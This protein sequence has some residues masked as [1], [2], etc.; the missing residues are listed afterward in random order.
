[1]ALSAIYLRCLAIF[2]IQ[3]RARST[4]Y[5]DFQDGVAYK[6]DVGLYDASGAKIWESATNPKSSW[7]T[8][9]DQFGWMGHAYP[10]CPDS[11]A[12]CDGISNYVGHSKVWNAVG[13][14][15][16]FNYLETQQYAVPASFANK[17]RSVKFTVKTPDSDAYRVMWND[18]WVNDHGK[19]W[20]SQ[21]WNGGQP[22]PTIEYPSLGL[23]PG[24]PLHI[25]VVD[26]KQ[27][28][29]QGNRVLAIWIS[30]RSDYSCEHGNHCC[31]LT[32]TSGDG[33]S[34]GFTDGHNCKID[35]P[36]Y[37][38]FTSNGSPWSPGS[39]QNAEYINFFGSLTSMADGKPVSIHFDDDV[40]S[41]IPIT[42][43]YAQ[44]E[45][46][47][48]DACNQVCQSF[49]ATG[50]GIGEWPFEKAIGE[51]QVKQSKIVAQRGLGP[52]K[53]S[54]FGRVSG[55]KLMNSGSDYFGQ[56]VWKDFD[57]TNGGKQFSGGTFKMHYKLQE[58]NVMSGLATISTS[59][60]ST[61]FAVDIRE[62]AIAWGPKRGDGAVLIN[63]EYVALDDGKSNNRPARL[64][65]VKTPGAWVDAA[66]GPNLLG[67]GSTMQYAYLHHADDL[68]KLSASNVKF[69]HITGLQ[70]N[71]GNVVELGNYG[72]GLRGG[73][74]SNAVVDGLYVHRIVHAGGGY[75]KNGGI[76]GTRTCPHGIRLE[77]VTVNNVVIPDLADAN[78]VDQ[79]FAIGELSGSAPFC[80]GRTGGVTIQDLHFQRWRIYV[81]PSMYSKFFNDEGWGSKPTIKNIYFYDNTKQSKSDIL[82]S[83][84]QIYDYKSRTNASN[85]RGSAYYCVCATQSGA[86]ECW[87]ANG[88]GN[89]VQN[90]VYQSTSA[91]NIVFPYGNPQGNHTPVLESN[92]VVV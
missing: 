81:N 69:S 73:V 8:K 21:Y 82:D 44:T 75:D 67:D 46:V 56:Q 64:W 23:Q 92:D 16:L 85:E 90:M 1:M 26:S 47:G 62:M 18:Q 48:S 20:Q 57:G 3:A 24:D 60:S 33:W 65:D 4:E 31:H 79:L 70:G 30:F 53:I 58:W 6:V 35:K 52:L 78:N 84:V 86:N 77:Q 88:P 2:A 59:D 17:V 11:P 55:F 34:T 39:G 49:Q 83:A 5:P 7:G 25:S 50:Q 41:A 9:P 13:G 71:I 10:L 66:D 28:Q 14:N 42:N 15:N 72:D 27:G 43:T 37:K 12:N 19:D 38:C 91:S 29:L 63:A 45:V 54:G 80:N 32:K 61:D 87:D 68:L 36:H 74:V 76:F 89:G 22:Q 40:E 51:C